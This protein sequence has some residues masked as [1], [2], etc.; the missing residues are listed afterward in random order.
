MSP[1]APLLTD[2]TAFNL[3]FQEKYH[4]PLIHVL[5][6]QGS[7]MGIFETLFKILLV[8]YER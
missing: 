3:G 6:P 5:S 1:Y 7:L 8:Y 2:S 4:E